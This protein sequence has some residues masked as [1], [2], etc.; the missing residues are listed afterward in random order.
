MNMNAP[1]NVVRGLLLGL[2]VAQAPYARA[3]GSMEDAVV[4]FIRE[5]TA[6]VA[7]RVVVQVDA[8]DARLRPLACQSFEP[9]LP[10]GSR[11]WGRATVGVRCAGGVGGSLFLTARVKV[12]APGVVAA[13]TLEPGKVVSAEDVRLEEIDITQPGMLTS[14]DQAT[15]RRVAVGVNAGFPVHQNVLRAEPVIAQ[16]DSVKLR[17]AGSGFEITADGIASSFALDGQSVQV[18]LES[19]RI[20]TGTARPGRVVE[21]RL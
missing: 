1:M 2:L 20:V 10:V 18:R 19:G 8:P 12:L 7:G 17:I 6:G 11:L 15:G 21:V 16:G 4:A 13:R 3:A 14:I 5:Q 9:F